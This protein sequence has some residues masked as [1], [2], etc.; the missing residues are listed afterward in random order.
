MDAP[1]LGGLQGVLLPELPERLHEKGESDAALALRLRSGGQIRVPLLRNALERGVERVQTR[2][3]A[4]SRDAHLPD[5]RRHEQTVLRAKEL[6]R[7]TPS[8]EDPA[9]LPR[10]EVRGVIA[11]APQNPST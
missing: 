11:V 7:T 9:R 1:S 6:N 3:G 5:R 10:S 8:D 4:A 2:Q